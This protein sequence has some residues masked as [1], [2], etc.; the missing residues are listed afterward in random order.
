MFRYGVDIDEPFSMERYEET[1]DW[2][3]STINRIKAEKDWQV[4]SSGY[5][6]KFICSTR[7]H[8]PVGEEI[9]HAGKRSYPT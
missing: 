8:C 4:S 9:I 3:E 1:L 7:D 6:C 5:F 2:I